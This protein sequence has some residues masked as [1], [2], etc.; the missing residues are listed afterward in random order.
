MRFKPK[1]NLLYNATHIPNNIYILYPKK[2][3]VFKKI[4]KSNILNERKIDLWKKILKFK[5]RVS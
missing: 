1:K 3:K 5:N 4:E 2:F